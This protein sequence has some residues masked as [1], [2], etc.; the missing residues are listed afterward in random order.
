MPASKAVA[1]VIQKHTH[2]L[3]VLSRIRCNA[4]GPEQARQTEEVS[5]AQAIVMPL[6]RAVSASSERINSHRVTSYP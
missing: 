6:T 1:T 5:I 4:S 2:D 3:E